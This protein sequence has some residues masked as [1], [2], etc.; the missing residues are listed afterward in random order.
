MKADTRPQWL[1]DLDVV[2]TTPKEARQIIRRNRALLRQLKKAEPKL[3]KKQVPEGWK[4]N[5]S[6]KRYEKKIGTGCPHCTWDDLRG[7]LCRQCKW[8]KHETG[9]CGYARFDGCRLHNITNQAP[10]FV[11]LC[12]DQAFMASERQLRTF[13]IKD[14]RD[15]IADIR[16][17]LEA[18]ITWGKD[19]I[20]RANK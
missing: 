14:I 18:H 4:L 12:S 6:K 11:V 2:K 7:F 1:I 17:F 13:K 16:K 15:C 10:I 20:R 19:V 8:K 3:L 9:D 5:A